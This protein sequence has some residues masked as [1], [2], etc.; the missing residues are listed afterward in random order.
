MVALQL[1][2]WPYS[3][4]QKEKCLADT[5]LVLITLSLNGV[6]FCEKMKVFLSISPK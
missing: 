3:N 1:M 2:F 6:I 5:L 4:I